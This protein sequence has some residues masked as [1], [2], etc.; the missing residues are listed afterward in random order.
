MV[1]ETAAEVVG[2]CLAPVRSLGSV[3]QQVM[4]FKNI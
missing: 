4:A 2:L 1:T 3:K